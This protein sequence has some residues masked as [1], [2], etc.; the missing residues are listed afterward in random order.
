MSDNFPK[1]ATGEKLPLGLEEQIYKMQ[2]DE[3]LRKQQFRHDW[4]IACFSS[5]TGALFGL[6]ASIIYNMY[7]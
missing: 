5:I 3:E 6:I 2:R 4:M 1:L 7:F